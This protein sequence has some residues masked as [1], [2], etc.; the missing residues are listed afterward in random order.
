MKGKR[1]CEHFIFFD[2]QHK[3]FIVLNFNRRIINFIEDQLSLH[4]LS[5]CSELKFK[6]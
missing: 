5:F 1:K 4:V 6:L 3:Y 2:F